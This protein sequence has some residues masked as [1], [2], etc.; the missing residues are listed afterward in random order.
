M[1]VIITLAGESKRFIKAGFKDDKFLL[2]VGDQTILEK[3]VNM[4]D[5]NND[6]FFFI[7]SNI[8][9]KNLI[10]KIINNLV[11]KKKIIVVKKNIVLKMG[12]DF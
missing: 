10:E 12:L 3:V 6:N 11:K 4:F 5:A 7:I 8:Q 9:N 1:N 2:K